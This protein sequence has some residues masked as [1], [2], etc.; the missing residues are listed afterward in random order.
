MFEQLNFRLNFNDADYSDLHFPSEDKNILRELGKQVAEIAARPVMEE[1]KQLWLKHNKLEKT[2]P[3]LLC[4]PENGWNE[5][6]P[7]SQI[8][9][10][11]SIARHWE[12]HLRKQIFWGNEMNDDYVVE[13]LFNLPYIY[14]EKS[15]GVAGSTKK[16]SQKKTAEEGKAYHI[17][18]ILEDFS[19]IKDITKPQ[20]T[21]HYQTT[22]SLLA[23]AQELFDGS[24]N[25]RINT[26]WFW[27]FGLTDE[28]VFLRGLEK[29]MY[30]FCDEPE[31]IHA[32]MKILFQGMQDKLDFLETNH[33][34]CLNNDGTYVGSG[35]MGFIDTL[36]AK[37]FAGTVRTKDMWGLAESQVTVGVSP[38]MFKEFIFPYQK[39][40]MERF[41]LTCYGCC[42]PMDARFDIVKAAANLRRVSVSPWANKE[43]MAAKLKHD[44]IYSLKPSPSNLALP[45]MDE[46]V[47]RKELK[48]AL[49]IAGEYDNCL[50]IIMKDNHTLGNNPENIKNWVK[51]AREEIESF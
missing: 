46:A 23:T 40:L 2:R 44:Y 45:V 24:L 37:D 22:E 18:T 4:D 19:Q 33:L 43:I 25:C 14:E 8:R 15:W 5:L 12:D 9:C 27:S 1:R 17:E 47:A 39:P 51:I 21:I 29:L 41:G 31:H 30:D 34:L 3:V 38:G 20:L 48:E 26:V 16:A 32:V 7:E 50:E 10:K 49:K 6:I 13:A 35:G 42:E 11:N 36:P 28:L